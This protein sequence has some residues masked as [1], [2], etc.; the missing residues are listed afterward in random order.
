MSLIT[1]SFG[2]KNENLTLSVM[3]LHTYAWCHYAGS[4]YAECCY[5]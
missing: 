5:P 4:C 2:I 1:M 3:K